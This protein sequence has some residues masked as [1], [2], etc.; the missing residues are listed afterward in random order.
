MEAPAVV[1]KRAKLVRKKRDQYIWIPRELRFDARVR[2]VDVTAAGG[3]LTIR[4]TKKRRSWAEFFRTGPRIS[5]D[6]MRERIDSAWPERDF[7]C[8]DRD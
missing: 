1:I 5:D 2:T 4:P 8:W 6:F 7:S 3:E